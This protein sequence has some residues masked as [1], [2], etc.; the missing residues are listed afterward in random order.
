MLKVKTTRKSLGDCAP[1]GCRITLFAYTQVAIIAP[2]QKPRAAKLI[3][4]K[5]FAIEHQDR[6]LRICNVNRWPSVNGE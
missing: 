1:R 4:I 3:E 2:N 6:H 5:G